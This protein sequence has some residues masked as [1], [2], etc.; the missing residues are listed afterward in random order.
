MLNIY[1]KTKSE[2]I[3]LEEEIIKEKWNVVKFKSNSHLPFV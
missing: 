3:V 2:S 1:I